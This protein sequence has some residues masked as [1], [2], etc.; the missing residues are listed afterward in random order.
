MQGAIDHPGEVHIQERQIRIG[1]RV[2]ESLDEV[3]PRWHEFVVLAPER[4][5][6]HLGDDPGEGSDPV[7]LQAGA[8][9]QEVG[10]DATFPEADADP[11]AADPNVFDA[12]AEN[13]SGP[14]D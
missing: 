11:T 3:A 14:L 9:D 12:G 8:I 6:P 2:D 1:D 10:M 4:H 7:R 5:H 13:Q